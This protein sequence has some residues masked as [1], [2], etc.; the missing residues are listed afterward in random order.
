[1]I[2]KKEEIFVNENH[3]RNMSDIELEEFVQKIFKYYRE[4]GFPYYSTDIKIREKEFQSLINYD[5]SKIFENDIIK[6]SIGENNKPIF[7]VR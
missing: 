7:R 6:Q 1:M 5:R 4:N 2:K 3:W